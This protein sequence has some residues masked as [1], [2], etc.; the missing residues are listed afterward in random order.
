ML[1]WLKETDRVLRGEVTRM[2]ALRGEQIEVSAVGLSVVVL[3]LALLYG[4]CMGCFALFRPEGPNYMQWVATTVKMPLLFFLTL[5]V[6]FPSLYVFNALVGSRLN[7]VAVLRLLIAALAT[8][9]AVLAS[10][11]P[12]VAFFSLSTTSYH[13]MLLLN[14][15]V[16]AVSGALGLGFL[17]HTL[18]RLNVAPRQS[19][20]LPRP[21][22]GVPAGGQPPDA[23]HLAAQ[24][25]EAG[26]PPQAAAAAE[27][28]PLDRLP[29]HVMGRQVKTV[30]NCWV[31]IFGLVGAQM[32]WVLRPFLG[33]PG[34]P[35]QWLRMRE[36]N[37]FESVFRTFLH[38]FS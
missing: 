17:L 9:L 31:I 32:G 33:A 29:G 34:A 7:V 38:L 1:R 16:F 21:T 19:P 22:P 35:F 36:S 5:V 13:F 15:V 27:L 14:V 37:F 23:Q 8:N 26:A 3:L 11:G 24:L 18:D 25:A 4:A 2:A 10:L 28:G 6:T 30:F 20:P 12:I